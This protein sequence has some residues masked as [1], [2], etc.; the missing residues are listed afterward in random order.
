M[1]PV[2]SIQSPNHRVNPMHPFNTKTKTNEHA[3]EDLS[4]HQSQGDGRLKK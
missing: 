3:N 4:Q 2:T 1:H